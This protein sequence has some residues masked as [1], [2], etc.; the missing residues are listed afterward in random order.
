[1]PAYCGRA[2]ANAFTIIDDACK[3][4]VELGGMALGVGI[5]LMLPKNHRNSYGIDFFRQQSQ[6]KG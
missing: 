4:G 6:L 3:E 5:G 2:L 1:M